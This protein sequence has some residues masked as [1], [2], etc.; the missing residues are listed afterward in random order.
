LRSN[1]VQVEPK[2]SSYGYKIRFNWN[3]RVRETGRKEDELGLSIM[4]F[5]TFTTAVILFY[6][7]MLLFIEYLTY[8]ISRKSF[9]KYILMNSK[10]KKNSCINRNVK[11]EIV[12]YST[13][14]KR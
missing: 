10:R 1:W 11:S 14:Y 3:P 6:D 2:V 12:L 9:L 5:S 7:S 8:E 13:D 4:E